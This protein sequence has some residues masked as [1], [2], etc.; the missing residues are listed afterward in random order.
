[1]VVVA[2]AAHVWTCIY[3]FLSAL[4]VTSRF[5]WSSEMCDSELLWNQM[6]TWFYLHGDIEGSSL[7]D[8]IYDSE[9][10]NSS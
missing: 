8:S 10:L 6:L 2:I 4:I 1:M 5:P 9:R 3:D 7:H